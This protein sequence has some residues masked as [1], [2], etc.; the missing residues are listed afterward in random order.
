MMLE[1]IR[2]IYSSNSV[3]FIIYVILLNP[4]HKPHNL[5]FEHKNFSATLC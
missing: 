4:H 2:G 1:N 3:D 5:D